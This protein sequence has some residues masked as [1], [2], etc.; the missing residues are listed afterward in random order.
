MKLYVVV[1]QLGVGGGGQWHKWKIS[2]SIFS[3]EKVSILCHFM[4][5]YAIEKLKNLEFQENLFKFS[6]PISKSPSH[7]RYT[8]MGLRFRL[9]N[10]ISEG[11]PPQCNT[12]LEAGKQPSNVR[13]ENDSGR[14]FLSQKF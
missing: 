8:I 2:F 6:I 3:I 12:S 5:F 14:N 11:R 13:I 9:C 10:A 4:P 7:P 1:E